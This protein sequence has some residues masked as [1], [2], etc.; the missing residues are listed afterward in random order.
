MSSLEPHDV[1]FRYDRGHITLRLPPNADILTAPGAPPLPD[2]QQALR[3][4][5]QNPIGSQPLADVA[6]DRNPRNVVITISDITRP[7]PNEPIIRA[8]LDELASADVT[9]DRVTILVATGMHR[10]STPEERVIML[11]EELANTLRIVDHVADDAS[12][13]T[14]VSDDP[15][16]S[17]NSLYLEADLKIV[18]GLIEPH[19]MAGYSGGRKGICPGIVDL[20]TISRFHGYATMS[21]RNSA[22]GILDGNPCHAEGLRVA[23]IAGCD[24]LVN[25]AIDDE[26]RLVALY[27][28]DI[29]EAHDVGCAEVGRFNSATIDEP[30]DLVV[31]CA[32]GYPLDE[33]FYQTVKGMV[34]ALPALREKSTLVIASR[35]AEVGSATYHEL[36]LEYEDNWEGFLRDIAGRDTIIKDQ[37]EFQMQTRVLERVGK[38]GLMLASDGMAET[39]LSRLCVTPLAGAGD[40]ADRVQAF[41]DQYVADHPDARVAAIPEGPYTMIRRAVPVG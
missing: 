18:T 21:N 1:T 22:E 11:G 19:F 15:P 24:F 39:D 25:C 40:V 12:S 28:G 27:A 10:P 33:S 26:R 41:I 34:T 37:W 13:L 9:P 16:V 20:A 3:D 6:R 8:I 38:Q 36:M 30:Y 4:A 35:C 29:E 17:V 7:V 2:P 5:L 31:T 14:R 23:R 32:G